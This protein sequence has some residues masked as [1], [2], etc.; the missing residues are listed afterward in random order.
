MPL[1]TWTRPK[2]KKKPIRVAYL[3]CSALRR[4]QN[5]KDAL[6]REQKKKKKNVEIFRQQ[7][8]QMLERSII[9]HAY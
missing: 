1:N 2:K 5:E 4:H 8:K 7:E 9:F 3:K 6:N